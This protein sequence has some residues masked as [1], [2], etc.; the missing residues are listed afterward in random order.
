[1]NFSESSSVLSVENAV[2]GNECQIVTNEGFVVLA[3]SEVSTSIVNSLHSGFV[4]IRTELIEQNVIQ[5]NE[6]KWLL[7]RTTCLK[8][9]LMWQSLLAQFFEGLW[10]KNRGCGALFYLPL[11]HGIFNFFVTFGYH[12]VGLFWKSPGKRTM[13]S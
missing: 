12:A 7:Q 6:K 5:Q 13:C 9:H 10:D 1:M 2:H 4:K 8:V 11:V 3:G